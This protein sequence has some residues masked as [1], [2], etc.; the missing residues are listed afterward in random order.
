[1]RRPSPQ[2][3]A[4]L[5]FG[6]LVVIW[7]LTPAFAK[8]FFH[9]ALVEFQAPSYTGL[10]YLKDLQ[11]YWSTRSRS[12]LELV[13]T[14]MALA[15]LNAAYEL[16]NQQ[17][18]AMERELDRLETLLDLPPLPEHK[19]VTAR[20]IRRDI[21]TWWQ[22]LQIR[23]GWVHGVQ[24]GQAVVYAGGAVG[25]VIEVNSYTAEVE[26]IS[27]PR[28]RMAAHFESDQR[29]VQYRGGISRSLQAPTGT[30]SFVPA[31]IAPES[32]TAPLRLVSS[33]LGGIFPDGLTLG[34]VD[35]LE[36]ASDGLFAEGQVRLDTR[37]LAL[38]EVAVLVPVQTLDE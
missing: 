28:F 15:R 23:K 9:R 24:V 4:L 8:R 22:R 11:L 6:G 3:R 37:L 5:L 1:M 14:G 18:T 2:I 17:A 25:R 16:R 27:S 20:V 35:T 10:S 19:Y 31:D 30:V 38:R 29:P 36:P 13:E 12:Q 7:F 34:F 26:L 32:A 21:A 33:R